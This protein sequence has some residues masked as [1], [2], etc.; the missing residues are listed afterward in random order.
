MIRFNAKR[1]NGVL[2]WVSIGRQDTKHS[3]FY[4]LDAVILFR[5]TVTVSNQ[6]HIGANATA[7]ALSV[8]C[9]HGSYNMWRTATFH[10]MM[11]TLGS[12]VSLCKKSVRTYRVQNW[13]ILLLQRVIKLPHTIM[14]R[15][16]F[17]WKW[18]KTCNFLLSPRQAAAVALCAQLSEPQAAQQQQQPPDNGPA[19]DCGPEGERAFVTYA[20]LPHCLRNGGSDFKESVTCKYTAFFVNGSLLPF[21]TEYFVFQFAIQTF[22]D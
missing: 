4:E 8:T 12:L 13:E 1:L 2:L 16:T 10:G 9:W 18:S 22:K 3:W 19:S 14:S 6:G 20:C 5:R 11:L 7:W 15:P 21:C 17:L